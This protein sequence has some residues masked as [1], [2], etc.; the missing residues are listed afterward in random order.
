[1]ATSVR[2]RNLGLQLASIRHA[3][4][5]AVGRVRRG[6]LVCTVPLQPTPASRTYTVRL[7]HRH[8]AP[9]TGRRHR[10]EARIAPRRRRP[11]ARL[12]RRS[13]LPLLPRRVGRQPRPGLHRAP[14]G[15]RMAPSLRA[16]GGNSHLARRRNDTRLDMITRASQ[17][18][19]EAGAP[20]VL[21]LFHPPG[22]GRR[23]RSTTT[24]SQS[25][26]SGPSSPAL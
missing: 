19:D 20:T 18:A 16:V 10:A 3:F 8:G 22:V 1:M 24:G 14:L 17:R 26:P 4:P 6:E 7:T 9:P 5:A 15:L 12:S 21:G 25:A 13:P 11:A 23:R 2:A